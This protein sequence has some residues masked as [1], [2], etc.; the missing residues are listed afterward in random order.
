MCGKS[1]SYK[2]PNRPWRPSP[3]R[4]RPVQ[5]RRPTFA[6]SRSPS[7]PFSYLPGPA[8]PH[9]PAPSHGSSSSDPALKCPLGTPFLTPKNPAF[10]PHFSQ[11]P[12]LG[13]PKPNC[14]NSAEH[15]INS[16]RQLSVYLQSMARR[17]QGRGESSWTNC[18]PF[19]AP[20]RQ[21]KA[22]SAARHSTTTATR[23]FTTSFARSHSL[24]PRHSPRLTR[25]MYL[26]ARVPTSDVF[27]LSTRCVAQKV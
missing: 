15:A 20:R 17:E 10:L 27:F 9:T 16:K 2:P 23:P 11:F 19:Q 21:Y 6:L 1:P 25:C 12:R 13:Q 8:L 18:L 26:S 24:L 7:H 5:R 14:E 22:S 4:E 3:E